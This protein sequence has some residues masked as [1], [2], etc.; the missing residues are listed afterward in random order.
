M[1]NIGNF[2]DALQAANRVRYR[3]DVVPSPEVLGDMHS[4]EHLGTSRVILLFVGGN[5]PLVSSSIASHLSSAALKL[6][7]K[8]P[9]VQKALACS[10]AACAEYEKSP[11]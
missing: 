7:G 3:P 2:D 5:M 11:R 9:H 6:A 1:G 8:P 10:N 4:T